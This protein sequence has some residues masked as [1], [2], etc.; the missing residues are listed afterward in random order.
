MK[1]YG[2]IEF[3]RTE[4]AKYAKESLRILEKFDFFDEQ[5][6]NNFKLAVDFMVNREF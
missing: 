6:K 5:T 1:K 2:S 4:A 3:G